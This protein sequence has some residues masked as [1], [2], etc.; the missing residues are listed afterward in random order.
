MNPLDQVLLSW[1]AIFL[2]INVTFFIAR[3]IDN[4][5]IID[6]FWGF[7]FGLLSTYFSL[8]GEGNELRRILLSTVACLWSFRLGIY[9]F[10]R[11]WKLHP[12]EDRRYA[13]LRDKWADKNNSKMFVFFHFQGLAIMVFALIF[14]VPTWNKDPDISFV[15]YLGLL[16]I[17]IAFLGEALAD[18]Q[19]A[20]FK[21]N[22]KINEVCRAGLW[23]YSRHPNYFFQWLAWVGYYVFAFNSNGWWTI[24][25]PI[26]MLFLLL[27]VTGVSNNEIQNIASKGDAYKKY[28]ETTSSFIPLPPKKYS[29]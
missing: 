18:L 7:S 14:A 22:S 12:K 8:T 2:L 23:N 17:I 16:L 19:L 25:C 29:S 3:T 13:D 1:A 27:K 9:L 28:Q 24:Y 20:R 11:C 26:L 4:A 10:I 21:K 5:G 15:E 6:V